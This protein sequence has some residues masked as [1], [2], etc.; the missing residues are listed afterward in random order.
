[1]LL[2]YKGAKALII[3]DLSEV[4]DFKLQAPEKYDLLR[5]NEL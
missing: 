4:T 2:L 3:N 1:M 5:I